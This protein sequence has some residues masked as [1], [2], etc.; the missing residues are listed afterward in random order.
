MQIFKIKK[1]D[2][3]PVLGATLTYSNG[4][5]IDLTNG[6]VFFCMGTTSYVPY[7]SGLCTITDAVDGMVQYNWL[8]TTDTGSIGNYFGEFKF[9]IGG[10]TMTLPND[11]SF[12]IQVNED[13]E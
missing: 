8:G 1:G 2:T 5:A 12:Q 9:I 10:S 6:S 13:F 11:S 7:M 4:S 3:I